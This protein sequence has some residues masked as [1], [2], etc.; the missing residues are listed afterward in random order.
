ML[1]IN[2]YLENG[3]G[4]NGDFT[5]SRNCVP[6]IFDKDMKAKCLFILHECVHSVLATGNYKQIYSLYKE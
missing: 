3:F 6:I 5:I 1:R 2:S 4:G